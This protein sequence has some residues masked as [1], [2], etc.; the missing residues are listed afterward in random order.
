MSIEDIDAKIQHDHGNDLL[1]CDDDDVI[2]C[3]TNSFLGRPLSRLTSHQLRTG[4]TSWRSKSVERL[5]Q[6][7]DMA[8]HVR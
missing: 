6:K 5:L 7:S 3:H 4:S 1:E 2:T 8:N